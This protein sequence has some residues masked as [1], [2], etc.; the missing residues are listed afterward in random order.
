MPD[1]SPKAVHEFWHQ[2]QDPI[3]YRV[4]SFMESVE[5]WILDD[6]P[7]FEKKM[8]ELGEELDNIS[9][10]N[11]NELGH[12]DLYIEICNAVSSGRAIRLL[13]AIDSVHP[14]SAS[15]VLIHAEEN[16]QN[17]DPEAELFFRRNIVF[18]RL[19]LLGRVFSKE[20]FQF[21]LKA[22]EGEESV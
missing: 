4:V 16:S 9:Q 2:Y 20:R 19:R 5:D 3:I 6:D 21:V 17:S 14:G 8:R 12:E 15:K 18:E 13:Q 22:I 11:L 1:L 7:D 10:I